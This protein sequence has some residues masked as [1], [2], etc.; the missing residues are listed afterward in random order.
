[1]KNTIHNPFKMIY[2]CCGLD[3]AGR[4]SLAGPLVSAGIVL[5]NNTETIIRNSGL[6][7]KDSK[8]MNRHEREKVYEFLAHVPVILKTVVISARQINNRGIAF[9]NREAFRMLIRMLNANQYIVDGNLR[10]G[11][12]KNKTEKIVSVVDADATLLPAILAGIVAKV[13]R[14]ALMKDLH[15]SYPV[16]LWH[17]NAGYGT[18][19]HIA[20]LR[21]HGHTKYHRNIFI[22]TALKKLI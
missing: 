11:R 5:T 19:E 21:I 2:P 16:Y 12:I 22:T 18:A 14:D 17:K 6:L 13:R 7:I 15:T 10:L 3:E 9:A 4:G 1:M 20:A 8:L